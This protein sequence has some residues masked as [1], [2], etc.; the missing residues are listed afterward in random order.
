MS[1]MLDNA[2][3]LA[4]LLF[5][6]AIILPM[7]FNTWFTINTDL[8]PDALVLIWNNLP[9][10]GVLGIMLSIISYALLRKR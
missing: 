6:S 9:L 3:E 8:F 5:V 7:A 1:K 2:I 4:V 10:I